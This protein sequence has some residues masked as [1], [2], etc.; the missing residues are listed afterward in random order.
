MSGK[1]LIQEVKE[2]T[3]KDKVIVFQAFG[4]G[5]INDN[6]MIADPGRRSRK[7]CPPRQLSKDYGIVP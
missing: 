7:C 4:R 6:G 5:T 2:K 1:K 3:K